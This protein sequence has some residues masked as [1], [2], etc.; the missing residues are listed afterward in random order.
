ML[1]AESPRELEILKATATEGRSED[2]VAMEVDGVEVRVDE[3]GPHDEGV[4]AMDVD[5]MGY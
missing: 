4:E 1:S 3:F 2:D 5:G